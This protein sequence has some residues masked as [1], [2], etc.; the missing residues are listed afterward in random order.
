MHTIAGL[1][2]SLR[3]TIFYLFA[4]GGSANVVAKCLS[5]AHIHE[6]D[7]DQQHCSAK[8]VVRPRLWT[9]DSNILGLATHC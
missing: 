8:L 6:F 5:S 9:A 2:Y 4:S 7:Q 1:E 3:E